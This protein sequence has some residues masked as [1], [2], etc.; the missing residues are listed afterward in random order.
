MTGETRSPNQRDERALPDDAPSV[1]IMNEEP[2]GSL[3][4][5]YQQ[6]TINRERTASATRHDGR[7]SSG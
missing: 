6:L 1:A 2:L 4:W 5:C 3:S 7:R